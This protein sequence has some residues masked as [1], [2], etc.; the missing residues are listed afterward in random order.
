MAWVSVPT[1]SGISL[2]LMER[3]D[4]DIS[5]QSTLPENQELFLTFPLSL[6]DSENTMDA[7]V[8]KE[9]SWR[10]VEEVELLHLTLK[11][12]ISSMNKWLLEVFMEEE[13]L[14]SA[15][16]YSKD[17]DGTFLTTTMLNLTSMVKVKDVVS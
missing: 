3:E 15:W 16:L 1:N 6:Q 7:Q 2:T 5:S 10:M 4:Q 11:E 17:L 14:N 8:Y 9:L 13:S 12:S